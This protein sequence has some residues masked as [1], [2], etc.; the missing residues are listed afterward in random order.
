MLLLMG[1]AAMVMMLVVIMAAARAVGMIMRV[2]G[3]IVRG[4]HPIPHE[5][6][7]LRVDIGCPT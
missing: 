6:D 3:V 1:V 7:W 4:F 2:S 5:C